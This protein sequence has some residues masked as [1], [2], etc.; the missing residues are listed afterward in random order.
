MKYLKVF[1]EYNTFI[2]TINGTEYVNENSNGVK[3]A[4]DHESLVNFYKWFGESKTVDEYN[5]PIVV[6]HIS[7]SK[8]DS[9]EI[10][11]GR[12]YGLKLGN[13][14]YFTSEI[15]YIN[16]LKNRL[17]N[18]LYECY[19]KIDRPIILRTPLTPFNKD[20]PNDGIISG[21]NQN[22]GEDEFK[23]INPNQIKSTDNNGIWSTEN[24]NIYM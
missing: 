13:G 6:Y 10:E 14:F 20:I 22:F 19:L 4:K 5:R 24:N 16:I 12:N 17:G 8:F 1:E 18:F 11:K 15:N 2:E 23:V 21:Y 7:N 3:I 9:F